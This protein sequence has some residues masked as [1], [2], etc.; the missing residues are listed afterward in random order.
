[1]SVDLLSLIRA[2][3]L[4][5][6]PLGGTSF[7]LAPLP[8]P[9]VQSQY[10]EPATFLHTTVA[11]TTVTTAPVGLTPLAYAPIHIR[12]VLHHGSYDNTAKI[13]H[14]HVSSG[15][16]RAVLGYTILFKFRSDLVMIL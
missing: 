1:L 11:H 14:G 16:P 8:Y 9:R 10:L 15:F 6:A 4:T 13:C 5:F 7:A 12:A 2:A 3:P